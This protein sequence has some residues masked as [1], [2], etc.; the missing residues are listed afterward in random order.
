MNGEG[1]YVAALR[2]YA[3]GGSFNYMA[4]DLSRYPSAADLTNFTVPWLANSLNY[5]SGAVATPDGGA[6]FSLLLSAVGGCAFLARRRRT[7]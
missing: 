7:A 5:S 1:V 4:L 3:N 6:V 2:N